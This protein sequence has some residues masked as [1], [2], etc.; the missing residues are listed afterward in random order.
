LDRD[1]RRLARRSPEWLNRESFRSLNALE[2]L[3][4]HSVQRWPTFLHAARAGQLARVSIDLGGLLARVIREFFLG[5]LAPPERYYGHRWSD[6][7][8]VIRGS[9]DGL[10]PPAVRCTLMETADGFR[11]L[12]VRGEE[13]A[14]LWYRPMLL[15][16][17][18]SVALVRSYLAAH[19]IPGL[20]DR[21]PVRAMLRRGV[22]RSLPG[23]LSPGEDLALAIAVPATARDHLAPEVELYLNQELREVA[24]GL[25][26]PGTGAPRVILCPPS[27]LTADTDEL[28][29]DGRRIH[30]VLP[31]GSSASGTLADPR[32]L[33][34]LREL[35]D[36]GRLTPDQNAL[37][38]ERVPW[39]RRFSSRR[40]RY[41]GEEIF[42]PA[43]VADRRH[44]WVLKRAPR[45]DDGRAEIL[46][47]R[48]TEEGRWRE[49]LAAALSD[50]SW[51]VQE[52]VRSRPVICQ[53]GEYGCQPHR[54]AWC[55][56]VFGGTFGGAGVKLLPRARREAIRLS[57]DAI[58][59]VV[60]ELAETPPADAER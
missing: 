16:T 59:G 13:V 10:D 11:L 46:I 58:E 33:A 52:E 2:S 27:E 17:M 25:G 6:V 7:A 55:T 60:L 23:Q 44:G 42:L 49:S 18:K 48:W 36:D 3:L 34:L 35:A 30:A 54:V 50:G 24:A 19:R 37:V 5:D 57:R 41:R 28:S 9:S 39:T 31:G 26:W 56:L 38:R 1:F 53:K 15:Q 14:G 45:D 4:P 51:V 32:H 47:G 20:R 43:L 40:C 22:E 12:S 29:R 21:D 8:E